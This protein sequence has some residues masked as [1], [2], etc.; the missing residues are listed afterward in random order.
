M[1]ALHPS[2][3]ITAP[4][5]QRLFQ[6]VDHLADLTGQ[7][8]PQIV[9][10]DRLQSLPEGSFGRAWIEM[11]DANQLQPLTTGPRRKQ[12][13]D[14]IHLLTGYGTDPLGEAEVQAFLL[15][16]K[17]CFAN[18]VLLLGLMR[19][20]RQQVGSSA[21]GPGWSLVGDRLRHA[22]WRGTQASFDPDTWQPEMLWDL[23][24]S[25]VRQWFHIPTP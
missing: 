12:L 10:R 4:R 3:Q 18:T 25:H 8:V 19:L 14:G 21:H 2:P 17:F 7:S 13:H 16:T 5:T 23:P 15:G 11:L 24:L 1:V 6:L 20:V 9:R 22:Y